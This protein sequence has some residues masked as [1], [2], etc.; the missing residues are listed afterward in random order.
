MFLQPIL[1]F[2]AVLWAIGLILLGLFM[3]FRRAS[4]PVSVHDRIV[5]FFAATLVGVAGGAAI[6]GLAIILGEVF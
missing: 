5:A 3:M 4:H 2:A 6:V 1:F